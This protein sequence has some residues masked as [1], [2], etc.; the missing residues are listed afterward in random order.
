MTT[1]FSI[2]PVSRK[3][4]PKLSKRILGM[5]SLESRELLSVNPLGVDDYSPDFVQ[6]NATSQNFNTEDGPAGAT[7]IEYT[8]G[9]TFKVGATSVT[10][11]ADYTL[12]YKIGSSTVPNGSSESWEDVGWTKTNVTATANSDQT[13]EKQDCIINAPSGT[14]NVY[15]TWVLTANATATDS[16][17]TANYTNIGAQAYVPLPA[18]STDPVYSGT[19]LTDSIVTTSGVTTDQ[20]T[21]TWGKPTKYVAASDPN[22][23]WKAALPKDAKYS[24]NV[25]GADGTFVKTIDAGTKTSCTITGLPVDTTDTG[26]KFT[27]TTNLTLT[28][29][30]DRTATAVNKTGVIVTTGEFTTLGT[31]D[32]AD[33][34]VGPPTDVKA[35]YVKSSGSKP[36]GIKVTWKA[37][38]NYTGGYTVTIK[39][40]STTA[41]VISTTINPGAKLEFTANVGQNSGEVVDTHRYSVIVNTTAT[42]SIEST[43]TYVNV[44]TVTAAATKPDAPTLTGG[45]TSLTTLPGGGKITI[46]AATGGTGS[47][48]VGF[49][50]GVGAT[51]PAVATATDLAKLVYVPLGATTTVNL[52]LAANNKVWAFA[53]DATGGISAASNDLDVTSSDFTADIATAL[54]VSEYAAANDVTGVTATAET[55]KNKY[56]VKWTAAKDVTN[57]ANTDGSTIA[58]GDIKYEVTGYRVTATSKSGLATTAVY[59][60][61]TNQA[62]GAVFENL[63]FGTEYTFKVEALITKIIAGGSN[64]TDSATV[65]NAISTGLTK[66]A[67]VTK[68]P[69]VTEDITGIT[70]VT[71][72]GTNFE[73]TLV[74]AKSGSNYIVTLADANKAVLYTGTVVGG[75]SSTTFNVSTADTNLKLTPKAKY[76]VTVQT[77]GSVPGTVSK[78]KSVTITA[79]DFVSATL[80][81]AK[82]TSIN[83]VTVAVTAPTKGAGSGDKYYIEYTNVVDAKSKPDWNAAQVYTGTTTDPVAVTGN[84][85][86]GKLDPNSQYFFRIV[87]VDQEYVSSSVGWDDMTK[88]A[89]SKELKIKTAAVPLP[90]VAKNGFTLD[91][92]SAF[93]LK[94][95]GNSMARVDALAAT[96]KQVLSSLKPSGAGDPLYVYTLIASLD[97]KTDKATGKLLGAETI[98]VNTSPITLTVDSNETPKPDKKVTDLTGTAAFADIF[99][100]LGIDDTNFSSVKGLNVQIQ[101]DVY[102]GQSN[103]GTADNPATSSDHFTLYSKASKVT[104]PK[105]FV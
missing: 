90:T 67:T 68:V 13:I 2:N 43:P 39:D 24:I 28:N 74:G 92:S 53:V 82:G 49:Y 32:A 55:V 83:S 73:V 95:V 63:N 94:L 104:L 20:V 42:N 8:S 35:T 3:N 71:N 56:T 34:A 57:I 103:N 59:V 29:S 38:A 97:S 54:P 9:T 80:R 100:A 64:W 19:A 6:T 65:S 50:V 1:I 61:K 85:I 26:Y 45:D 60:S 79:A 62:N 33:V 76:T 75:S 5:E 84:V 37:P 81:D 101:V 17:A 10:A 98:K 12:F 51:A 27:I 66:T 30:A 77:V 44:G 4:L 89:T 88:V 36:A 72:T 96:N 105:W 18:S 99:K 11:N 52:K 87:T 14:P 78:G 58:N 47:T 46:T 31:G 25:F 93:G 23:G 69:A 48:P 16:D 15:F 41:S 22:D 21:L 86:I 40:V 91:S 70:E 7:N 102:Y